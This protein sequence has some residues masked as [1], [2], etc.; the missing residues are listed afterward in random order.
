M[1]IIK[2]GNGQDWHIAITCEIVE[3][4]YGLTYDGD[5]EH[6][7]SVHEISK[8][9]ITTRSW[10]KYLKQISRTDYVTYCP[11]C[12]CC[13]YINP[14]LLPEWVKA[15]AKQRSKSLA[16]AIANAFDSEN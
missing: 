7:G 5:K 2:E 9:D 4:N 8:E 10:S 14:A 3:D 12:N 13:L 6:C 11:K 1:K 15:E 16:T